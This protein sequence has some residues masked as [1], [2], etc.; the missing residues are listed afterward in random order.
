MQVQR[1]VCPM[2]QLMLDTNNQN[3][4]VWIYTRASCSHKSSFQPLLDNCIPK[5][6]ELLL[7]SQ[8]GMRMT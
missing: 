3:N 1:Q 4:P 7:G 2:V 5:C 6:I 8:G